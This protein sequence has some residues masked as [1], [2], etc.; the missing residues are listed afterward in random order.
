MCNHLRNPRDDGSVE[1]VGQGGKQ[2]CAQDYGDDDLH[3]IGD[4]EVAALVGER[5][6]GLADGIVESVTDCIVKFFHGKPPVGF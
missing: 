5:L 3:G 6:A 2:Q 4:V 1:D